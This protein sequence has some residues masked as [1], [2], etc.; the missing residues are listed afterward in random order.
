[1]VLVALLGQALGGAGLI[2]ILTI[3]WKIARGYPVR[4]WFF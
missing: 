1:M 2:Y 4:R 3:T